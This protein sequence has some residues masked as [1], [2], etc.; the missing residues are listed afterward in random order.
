MEIL[1]V[2]GGGQKNFRQ[3][4]R[5]SGRANGN[6]SRAG[7]GT[8]DEAGKIF[9]IAKFESAMV[10][11]SSFIHVTDQF[12]V[13]ITTTQGQNIDTLHLYSKFSPNN[14]GWKNSPS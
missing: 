11:K 13:S 2:R 6:F 12:R 7:R 8:L 9:F 4:G 14:L 3:G 10:I 1:T 5:F